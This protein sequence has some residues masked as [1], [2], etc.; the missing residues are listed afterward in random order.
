MRLNYKDIDVVILCAGLGTR[1]RPLTNAIPKVMIPIDENLPLLEHIV[2]LLKS[3]GFRK[4]IFNLHYLPEVI[5]NHFGDGSRFG[6][7]IRYSLESGEI[8]GTGGGIKKMERMIESEDF[9][10]IYGDHLFIFDFRPLVDFHVEKRALA[11]LLLKRSD[12]P[13]NGDLAEIDNPTK[14]ITKWHPRPHP[15]TEYGDNLYLNTGLDILS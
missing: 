15:Y 14:K 3:Q 1:L 11:T 2:L 5:T 6:V 7:N 12:I 8:L 10:L 9:I 4:F 13:Q